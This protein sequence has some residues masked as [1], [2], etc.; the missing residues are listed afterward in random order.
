MCQGREKYS[1]ALSLLGLSPSL[2]AEAVNI[3]ES[4]WLMCYLSDPV[5]DILQ[6]ITN[7][8][9]NVNLYNCPNGAR[10]K[11]RRMNK[12]RDCSPHPID[13]SK[14]NPTDRAVHSMAVIKN[15]TVGICFYTLAI[16]NAN[17]KRGTKIKI[18]SLIHI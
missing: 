16:D 12:G 17:Q 3:F 4:K 9:T 15:E 2:M 13:Q 1:L 14:Y 8:I 5:P 18:L 7:R 11:S 6:I 10:C